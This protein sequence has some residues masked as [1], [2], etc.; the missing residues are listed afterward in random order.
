M[1]HLLLLSLLVPAADPALPPD[2]AALR[3]RAIAEH[4]PL[5]VW[6]GVVRPDVEAVRPDALHLRCA[7]F[8]DATPPC[9]VVGRPDKGDLWRV[10]DLPA[11]QADRLRPVLRRV[12]GPAGCTYSS[13]LEY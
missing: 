5:I 2:Y 1:S 13:V 4:R 10:V 9:A 12:C 8:P 7:A 6:V 3:A 11:A